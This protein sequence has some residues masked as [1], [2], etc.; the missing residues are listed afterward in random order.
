MKKLFFSLIFFIGLISYAAEPNLSEC[1]TNSDCIIV[2]YRHC[3]GSTK[4][5]INKKYQKDYSAHPEWQK[6]DN[7]KSCATIGACVSDISLDSAVCAGKICQLQMSPE[8]IKASE[9]NCRQDNDC[10]Q[11]GTAYTCV[12]QRIACAEH[13]ESSTCAQRTC[14]KTK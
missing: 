6:F 13:P 5:A 12:T 2:P 4:K 8:A 3:C 10:S 1:E 11:F 9:T 14:K 7:A